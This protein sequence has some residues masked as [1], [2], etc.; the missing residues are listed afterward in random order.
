[1][2]SF[3]KQLLLQ[4]GFRRFSSSMSSPRTSSD[5]E[6]TRTDTF[7]RACEITSGTFSSCKLRKKRK[8]SQRNRLLKGR[9]SVAPR[10]TGVNDYFRDC[11]ANATPARNYRQVIFSLT[12]L[13]LPAR[14]RGR[15]SCAVQMEPQND[16][17]A[18]DQVG[19]TED[20]A[21][22]VRA[23]RDLGP[24]SPKSPSVPEKWRASL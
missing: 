13:E 8:G 23:R 21:W 6:A 3:L 10:K 14:N 9:A 22:L 7:A 4:S 15:S 1:L 24:I 5:A 2:P 11:P 20:R 18:E 12:K 19:W 16:P 17:F